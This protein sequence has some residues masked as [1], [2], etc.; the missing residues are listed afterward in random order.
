MN[1]AIVS[2]KMATDPEYVK[3]LVQDSDKTIKRHGIVITKEEQQS[4]QTFLRKS[5]LSGLK[6][7]GNNMDIWIDPWYIG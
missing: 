4:L 5:S 3:M 2:Y 7:V 1:M 6:V